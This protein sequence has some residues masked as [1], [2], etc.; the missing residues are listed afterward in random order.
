[1]ILLLLPLIALALGIQG[2]MVMIAFGI[3]H[4]VFLAV[5]AIGFGTSVAVGVA[6]SLLGGFFHK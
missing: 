1:M 6:L 5:P 4:S 3:L 2:F